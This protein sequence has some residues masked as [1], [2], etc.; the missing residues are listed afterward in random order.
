MKQITKLVVGFAVAAGLASAAHAAD[1]YAPEAVVTAS[2]WYLRADAGFSWLNTNDNTVNSGV[3][4]GGV[5]YQF[6]DNLRTDLRVDYAGLGNDDH[7]LTT[8]LG[9]LYFDVPTQTVMTP[10]LGAGL[11]YGWATKPDDEKNGIAFTAMAGVAIHITDNVSADVGYRYRQIFSEDAY[12]N[13]ALIGLRY[14]F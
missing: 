13:E 1:S 7:S 3:I 10:Y 8:A 12:D 2:S 5:G 6:N 4:G 9:N 11:G 14:G